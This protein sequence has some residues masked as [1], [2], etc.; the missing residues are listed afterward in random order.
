MKVPKK[1]Q[2]LLTTYQIS[3]VKNSPVSY[4]E[5]RQLQ[6]LL[7]NLEILTKEFS[8]NWITASDILET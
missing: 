5:H 3:G 7:S 8:M 1:S 6:P 4:F 2:I